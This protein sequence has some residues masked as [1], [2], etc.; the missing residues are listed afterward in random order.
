M[1]LKISI[2]GLNSRAGIVT[3]SEKPRENPQPPT[4]RC[5]DLFILVIYTEMIIDC[6]WSLS[7]Q[8]IYYNILYYY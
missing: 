3:K 5:L 1:S 2:T 8:F 4:E 6:D 7:V